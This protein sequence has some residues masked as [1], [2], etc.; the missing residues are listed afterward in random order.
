MVK[1]KKEI[2]EKDTEL[3]SYHVYLLNSSFQKYCDKLWDFVCPELV[4]KAAII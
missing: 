2:N 4:G 1:E 3:P